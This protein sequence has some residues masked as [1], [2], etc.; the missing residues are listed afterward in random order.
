MTRSYPIT[1]EELERFGP[2]YEAANPPTISVWYNQ[3]VVRGASAPEPRPEVFI[4][5]YT[6]QL[7]R[8]LLVAS[9]N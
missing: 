6:G 4:S 2:D 9:A 1:G 5:E 7:T 8:Q 3:T